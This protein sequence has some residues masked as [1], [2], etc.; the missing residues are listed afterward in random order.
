MRGVYIYDL[1]SRGFST[2]QAQSINID[3]ALTFEK[4][5]LY[6]YLEIY[7]HPRLGVCVYGLIFATTLSGT[8]VKFA[9]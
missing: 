1:L 8:S 2:L 4:S 6:D 7:L 5:T 9:F 3:Q